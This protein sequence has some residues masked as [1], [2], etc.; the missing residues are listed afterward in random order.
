MN[1]NPAQ[2]THNVR[3]T[4]LQRYCNVLTWFQR[5]YNV[6]LT[7]YAGWVKFIN[8]QLKQLS[9]KCLKFYSKNQCLF[10]KSP[11]V[12]VESAPNMKYHIVKN[13]LV[14]TAFSAILTC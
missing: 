14:R 7:L 10:P 3:T 4:L 5:P 8:S 6:V 13:T 12:L 9:S 2:P 11:L 1:K